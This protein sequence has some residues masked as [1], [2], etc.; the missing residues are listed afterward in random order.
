MAVQFSRA[1]MSG[2]TDLTG[3]VVTSWKRSA[4][5]IEMYGKIVDVTGNTVVADADADCSS[6]GEGLFRADAFFM[7]FIRGGRMTPGY[8]PGYLL[9]TAVSNAEHKAIAFF[10]AVTVGLG[11]CLWRRRDRY[12]SGQPQ[13]GC[14]HA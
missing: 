13:R 1:I 5:I 2:L 9:R 10:N 3:R 7:R 14:L 8:L 6:R 4:V 11:D 12:Y